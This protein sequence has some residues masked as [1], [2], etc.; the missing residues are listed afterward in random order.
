MMWAYCVIS[1]TCSAA[2]PTLAHVITV[3][4]L[5]HLPPGLVAECIRI[6]RADVFQDQAG[7]ETQYSHL[8]SPACDGLAQ[9]SSPLPLRL[10]ESKVAILYGP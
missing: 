10:W 9:D 5:L 2:E 4:R 6:A 1:K 7:K 8:T 3:K